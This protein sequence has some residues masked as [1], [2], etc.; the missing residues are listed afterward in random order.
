MLCSL[1]GTSIDVWGTNNQINASGIIDPSYSCAIDNVG[2]PTAATYPD[3]NNQILCSTTVN[4]GQ[5]MLTVNV[6][7]L[8]GQPFWLDD[9][10]YIP[11]SSL[12]EVNAN[13]IVEQNDPALV[14][15]PGWESLEVDAEMT[16]VNGANVSLN[17]TGKQIH[18][19]RFHTHVHAVVNDRSR[20]F[21]VRP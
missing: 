16:S 17:F 7:S 19:H 2:F 12:S 18:E 4:G 3:S 21:L 15:S 1:L 5:H 20:A 8:T 14:Y 10:H 9:I 6:T 11:S 13:I